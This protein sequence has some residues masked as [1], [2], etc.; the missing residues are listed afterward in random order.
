MHRKTF[1]TA[2]VLV[3]FLI[4][5][6]GPSLSDTA[7]AQVGDKFIVSLTSNS[8]WVINKATRKVM[9]FKYTRKA[10]VWKSNLLILPADIDLDNCVLQSVG[11]AAFLYDKSSDMIR[12]YKP[13][14]DGSLMPFPDFNLEV[15]TK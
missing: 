1:T 2:I 10:T 5:V 13:L 11:D 3:C 6:V 14:K 4:F 15:E 9:F 12:F 7:S 8:G